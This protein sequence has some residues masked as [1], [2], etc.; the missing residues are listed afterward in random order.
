MSVEETRCVFVTVK[1]HTRYGSLASV[2]GDGN[3]DKEVCM[4]AKLSEELLDLTVREKGYRHALYASTAPG[5]GGG[6]SC[7]GSSSSL[8]C[9]KLSSS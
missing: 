2:V 4:F 8:T 6:S 9:C 3:A 1:A 5:A 7:T